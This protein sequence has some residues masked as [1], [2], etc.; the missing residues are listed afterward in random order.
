MFPC[1]VYATC[2]WPF[3]H[4]EYLCSFVSLPFPGVPTILEDTALLLKPER[5]LPLPSQE[6]SR[7]LLCEPQYLTASRSLS[8][9]RMCAIICCS[10]LWFF[11]PSTACSFPHLPSITQLLQML[12]D[13]LLSRRSA[14]LPATPVPSLYH[15]AFDG[16]NVL[17]P[18]EF[19]LSLSFLKS[20]P[21]FTTL[22]P[23]AQNPDYLHVYHCSVSL[24]LLGSKG[25]Q[26]NS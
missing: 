2:S 25:R 1:A 24:P 7:V 23:I 12:S 5:P 11:F 22:N 26:P 21:L 8:T 4:F 10:S 17:H 16:S 13:L 6:Q 18:R 20:P 9:L 3:V 15:P 19:V 14:C